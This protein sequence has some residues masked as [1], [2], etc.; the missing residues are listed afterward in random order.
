VDIQRFLDADCAGYAEFFLTEEDR[1]QITENG[2]IEAENL[3]LS[4]SMQWDILR[5]ERLT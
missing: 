3:F 2:G 4:E 1:Q 5:P